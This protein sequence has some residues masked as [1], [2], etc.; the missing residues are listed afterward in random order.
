MAHYYTEP[1]HTFSEY[2]LIP[3]YTS[4]DCI[5]DNVSLRTPLVRYRKGQEE[6]P[7]CLN[8][9]MTSAIMQSVSNDT[10]AI[11]LAKEGGL[12]FIYGSQSIE[13]EAEMV[14]RV[15]SHKAGFV[16]SASNLTP[17]HT[18]ADVLALKEKKRLL[19][20]RHYGERAAER[21]ASRHRHE[22]RLPGQPDVRGYEGARL[23][24]A[25]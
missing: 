8:I 1:S 11:A 2:L 10:L 24:D 22:P 13:S 12:S 18:L 14:R 23:H 21:Q 15:K 17:E 4:E 20:G 7:I 16:V 6:C 5:P 19:Y 9:P 3:G 25:A